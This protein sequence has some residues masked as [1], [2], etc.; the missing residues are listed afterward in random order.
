MLANT[1]PRQASSLSGRPFID[2]T[3][4]FTL[5]SFASEQN[6]KKISRD[7]MQQDAV[8]KLLTR[9]RLIVEWA[10]GAG[11]S[12]V[13]ILSLKKLADQGKNRFL[14]FVCETAHK[15]NWRREFIDVL[16]ENQ[17]TKLWNMMT[18]ECYNSIHKYEWTNWECIVCD[19]AHHL[20][21][22]KRLDMLSTIQGKHMLCL[23]ATLNESG[24]GDKL[25]NILEET[26]GKFE[27]VNLS[28]QDA[29]N[30][31]ILSKPR[32]LVHILPLDQISGE[33]TV[34]VN[35]GFTKPEW[36]QEC[37]YAE[38][39]K[40]IDGKLNGRIRNKRLSVRC[41]AREGYELLDRMFR[42]TKDEYLSGDETEDETKD[43]SEGRSEWKKNEM[44]Q[45]GMK[46]KLHLGNCKTRFVKSLI[47]KRL[48][49]QRFICFCNDIE[50]AKALGN[51]SFICSDRNKKTNLGIIDE[52]NEG[53]LDSIYAVGMIQ[54]GAN[55]K[56]IEA[57]V[58]VQLGGKERNFIQKFGRAMRSKNPVQHIVVIDGT[59]DVKYFENSVKNIEG[60]YLEYRRY[61]KK[62]SR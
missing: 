28:L 12:R 31:D 37:G 10:T 40:L 52:F 23:S 20:R 49:G 25:E 16:G 21:S 57:G 48:N 45:Y 30:N 19:E 50:Q 14:M 56:G 4:Y 9:K 42:I 61:G 59:Q 35:W 58:I 60:M 2:T 22:D 38:A 54:E 8:N 41:T 44:L 32:I 27:R 18:V 53:K 15:N 3:T 43:R 29:I 47:D 36:V 17:G 62:P 26:F 33:F 39:M 34:E 13:A 7:E 24:D 1:S 5:P 11:K 46:R 6:G 55:L 51:D